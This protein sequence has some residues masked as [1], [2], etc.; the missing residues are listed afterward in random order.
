M[1]AVRANFRSKATAWLSVIFCTVAALGC[2]R[3]RHFRFSI[4]VSLIERR[5]AQFQHSSFFSM[6]YQVFLLEH[7]I[8]RQ[9]ALVTQEAVLC[10]NCDRVSADMRLT[11][12]DT[13]RG[14]VWSYCFV[15]TL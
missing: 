11:N 9:A 1:A 4:A 6:E 2:R 3:T 8:D 12:D 5:R 15:W 7:S 13:R 14:N 10:M